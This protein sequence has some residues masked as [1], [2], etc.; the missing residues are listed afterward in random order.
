[1]AGRKYLELNTT[2]A[3]P[4]QRAALDTSAGAAS[5]TELV[6]LDAAGKISTTMLPAGILQTIEAPAS[7]AL[8]AGDL[9]NFHDVSGTKSVRKANATD[10]TKPAE[11]FVLAS[12]SSSATATVYTDG[13]NTAVAVGSFVAA[14]VGKRVFLSATAGLVTLT[15]PVSTGN[16]VQDVGD[17]V[18][19]GATVTIDFRV[20]TQIVA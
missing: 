19:V 9:I 10:A 16:L 2:T 20:G 3:R 1:M 11:G 17:I 8:S 18:D 13:Q 4:T 14:D 7:E 5:A 12:V 6:A 15:P